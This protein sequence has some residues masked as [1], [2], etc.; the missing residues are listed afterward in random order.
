MSVSTEPGADG[1]LP[2][3]SSPPDVSVIAAEGDLV[4]DVYC[5]D[6]HGHGLFRVSLQS[7][8]ESSRYFETLLDPEKFNE[9]RAIRDAHERLRSAGR[10]PGQVS[11]S[12]LP[13]LEISDLGALGRESDVLGL[14]FDFLGILHRVP[15]RPSRSILPHVASLTVLADRFGCLALL[16]RFL[17]HVSGAVLG[18][19]HPSGEAIASASRPGEDRFRQRLLVGWLLWDR[20]DC[21]RTASTHLVLGGSRGWIGETRPAPE[22]TETAL[23]WNLP[24][25]LEVE[26]FHRREC[27]LETLN[28]LQKQLLSLYMTSRTRQCT[29][30]YDSSPQ[31]DSFQLGQAVRFFSRIGT[32]ELRGF[33]DVADPYMCTTDIGSLMTRMRQCPEYQIDANH[34]HCGIRAR[35]MP[36]LGLI[37][38]LAAWDAGVC[39]DCWKDDRENYR[40]S[41][42]ERAGAW[43]FQEGSTELKGLRR[44]R[45]GERVRG[46]CKF[47]HQRGKA[48][49]TAKSRDWAPA[50]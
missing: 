16:S 38:C 35:L 3:S 6:K 21:V 43:A 37:E 24:D 48:L 47:W 25:D 26:L 13:R 14:V 11:T 50:A 20:P 28:S 1:H 4:L 5:G 36:A 29:L 15:L 8:R 32:V 9:G 39:R 41:G 49:F 2:G 10:T 7:L 27:I 31:C 22:E 23:W 34:R 12:L 17:K 44:G 33:G 18:M 30:G 40:W 19:K 46:R 45:E 42:V